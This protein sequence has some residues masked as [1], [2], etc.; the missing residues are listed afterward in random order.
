[1][2]KQLQE[3]YIQRATG[4][5]SALN[6]YFICR[7]RPKNSSESSIVEFKSATISNTKNPEWNAKFYI[8]FTEDWVKKSRQEDDLELSLQLY[9][10]KFRKDDYIGQGFPN[11]FI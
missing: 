5:K 4:L 7:I 6:A 9:S 3:I 10:E 11:F 8:D 1:M 2:S